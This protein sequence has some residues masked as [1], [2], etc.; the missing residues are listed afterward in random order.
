MARAAGAHARDPV[1][2]D[3][4]SLQAVG[5]ENGRGL[6]PNLVSLTTLGG[7]YTQDFNALASTGTTGSSLPTDWTF[8]ETGGAAPTTYGV[9]TGSS[10][11]GDTWSYGVAGVNPVTD[12]AFGSLGSGTITQVLIGTSFTNNTG[13]QINSLAISYFG[14]QWRMGSNVTQQKLDFQISFDATSLTTGTWTDVNA[15][16]FLSIV[17]SAAAA[18]A[19]DGNAAA[20]RIS[21][22]STITSLTIANGA[23]FWIRW[24]DVND[25]GNDHGLAIDDFSLTPTGAAGSPGTLSIDDVSHVEGNSGATAYTFTVSRTGGS[26]GAVSADYEVFSPGTS[27]FVNA[28]DFVPGS[29]FLGTVNFAD[30]QLSQT[31]TLNIQGDFTIE[32][33]ETFTVLLTNPTGGATITDGSGLGTVTN[34]DSAGSISVN[35][36]S[37]VEGNAGTTAGFFTLTRSGGVSGAVSVDYVIT[38]PGGVGGADGSDVSGTLTGTVN[39]AQGQTSAQIDF[40]INGDVTN[41][42]NETF[43]VAL[44]NPTGGVT[45]GDGAGTATIT[46]DDNPPVISIGDASIVEGNAGVSYISFTIS[47]DKISVDPVTVNYATSDNSATA[48]S[49]Y[50]AVSGQVSFDPGQT[51]KTISVPIIGDTVPEANESF[52]VTLSTPTG[53]TIGDGSATGTITN[54]DGQ[55]YFALGGGNFSQNWT[56]TGLITA[57]DNWS[58]VPFIVGKLGQDIT[59]GTGTNPGTLTGDSTLPNDIDVIANQTSTAITNGGVAEFEIANPTVALQGSGTADAP[60]LILFMDSTGRQDVTVSYRL[61]DIDGTADNA[62]M[63][64]ALQYRIGDSGPWINVPAAFVA[65]A[66]TGPSLA[67]LETV[68]TATLPADANNQAALQIRIMTT[69]AVGND[70]WVGIDDIVVSSNVSAPSLSIADTAVFE[71]NAGTTPISFTVT[72]AG[73]STGA[74]TADW[75][76]TFGSGP[77]DAKAN[78]FVA[79]QLFTGNVSFA[80]GET[81]KVITLNVQG[82]VAAEGDDSFTV[83]LSNPVGGS[84]ADASAIGTIVNDD[85]PP[86][87]ISINDVTVT[88]GD[89]G[90]S[91]MTFTVT[92]TGGSQAFDVDFHTVDDTAFAGEDYVANSGTISFLAGETSKQ[93]SI[94]INGDTDAE[95]AERFQ[96]VL[97]DA[98]N[99]ALILDPVGVGTIAADDP[100]FIH[101]IQGTSYF[102]PILAS[103]GVHN[104]NVASAASVTVRAVVTAVDNVGTRQG[105]YLCE[106]IT[107]WDGN[108]Y[109][110]EGIFVMTRND[111]GV[112]TVVSGVSVGDLV[113]V[114][115]Q[116]MEYQAFSSMPRTVLVNSTGLSILST[117]NPLP[118]VTLTNMPNAVMTGVTPDYFD[119]SDGVG[120]SFDASV[121]A[122]SYYETV[123][124]MLVTIPNM[125]VADGFVTTSGGDPVLQAYSL[126][127]ANPDQINSRGGYTIAGDPP[128]G[129]PDT[130]ETGD[131]THN[132]GRVL[133]DGDVNPDVIEIDFTDF[134]MAPPPGLTQS[135]SMGDHI[136]D[137]TGIIDFDFT[138]RKLFVTSIDSSGATNNVPVRESTALGNDDRALTVAT[139]NVENLDPGD[140]AARF[141]A[142]AD[143]IAN[144]LNAPDILSIEEMQDNNGATASGG[145]DASTTWQMLVDA[146]NLAT[147]AHYQWV[148]QEPVP[149]GEGGEPGGNI[150]VG[151]LYN[152]DRVQL[153]DL[154]PDATLAERRQ[155]TDRLGDGVRDAG[156]LIAYSD[157]MLGGEINPAD[158]TGTRKS[159]LGEFTF[160]GN[161]VYVTANHFPAKG[162]SGNFWQIDQTLETGNPDNSGWDQRNRVGQDLY[163][164]LNLI[165]GGSPNAGIVSGGD[166]NDFYFYRP[167]TTV[168]G[169]TLADGTARIGGA[170]FENLTLSLPEAE[171]YTYTFDGRSQAI[172]HIVV[173]NLLGGVATYDVVHINTGYN[174]LGTGIDAVTRLS[175]HDPG[176]SSYDFRSFAETL[177]GSAAVDTIDGFGGNDTINGAAGNDVLTGNVGDDTLNGGADTDTAVY[178]GPLEDYSFVFEYDLSGH[179]IGFLSVTD[180]NSSNGDEGH[181]TLSSIEVLSFAG[182]AHVAVGDKVTL[183]DATLHFLGTFATIQGAI[184]AASDGYTIIVADGTFNED[185][186]I[187]VDVTIR[188]ANDGTATDDVRDP[189]SV[190][191]GGVTI[192]ANGVTIDGF[193][194]TGAITGP[195]AA[196]ASGIYVQGDDFTLVNTIM[197]G[198]ASAAGILTEQVTG[199]DVGFNQFSGY[200]TGVYVSGGGSAGEIHDNLFQGDG[201]PATGLGNGV[202]SETSGVLI[203]GNVFDGIYGGSLNLFPNGPDT[204]DLNEYVLGNTITNSGAER[205]VQ[206]LP[207]NGTHNVLGTDYNEAFDGETAAANGVTGAFSFNGRGGDDHMWGGQASDSFIGGTGEDEF[208]GEGG[209][210]NLAGGADFDT[211]FYAGNILDYTIV[212]EYNLG[213][214]IIGFL[215]VT[216]NNAGDGDEGHDTLSSIEKL[217]F[218]NAVID[219][220]DPIRLY[221]G[222]DNLVGT[223]TSIQD[224]IDAS[225]DGYRITAE[226]GTYSEDLTVDKDVTIEGANQGLAGTDGGRGAE[227]EIDGS[228]NV[229]AA[230]V[231][232][233]G[234][235]ITGTSNFGFDAGIYLQTDDFTLVNSV[236]NGPDLGGNSFGMLTQL[237][238]NLEVAN[239]LIQG[240]AVGIYISS[241]DSTGSVHDNL[242]QGDGGPITGMGNG[243]NSETSGVTIHDNIFDGIY[244][245][246]INVFPFGPDPVD[247]NTYIFDNLFT[248]NAGEQVIQV[249]PTIDSLN[250]I[251]TD[252]NESF[253]GD[254]SGV[255]G[256]AFSFQGNGGDDKAY[257]GALG[258]TF[259]GGAGSDKLYGLGG[260]DTLTG[261]LDNDFIDGGSG[262]DTANLGTSFG[263]TSTVIGWAMVNSEGNDFLTSVE[264]AQTGTQRNLLVG[265]TALA[266]IQAASN[267][268]VDGDFIQVANGTW[269]GTVT[270]DDANLV[271][272]AQPNAILNTTFTTVT[273]NGITVFGG[274]NADHITTSIGND[275]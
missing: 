119:S 213:G 80:S 198:S 225:S 33:D 94:T 151:F 153:G 256:Q 32:P 162:G 12:R 139:F 27:G 57:N 150:R 173:N 53:A 24:V 131:D 52:L 200:G 235:A 209:N 224:A 128:I 146:V 172:D 121:Y 244:A 251:G 71:G 13:A 149:G 230:G 211:A 202:N 188:G 90:T 145:A 228:V 59:T 267:L 103:E 116:V 252:E 97:T 113:Q 203:Q 35:D 262:I 5:S 187:D 253:N 217:V 51:S 37:F 28:L 168:T 167:L 83:T 102:S 123:E 23:T 96:V 29:V 7:A 231:T 109:T 180:N 65:D 95:F 15:L 271:V 272:I 193:E 232:L 189:E 118:A 243:V 3:I 107:D 61:R 50:V 55:A 111:A 89:A 126:D 159:L 42:P 75:T 81:S 264:I 157:D 215:E 190:I 178:A 120:D 46:N 69:N 1:T 76:V 127:S 38:L 101:M 195:G 73:D 91:L 92:R 155:Y 142:I 130:P 87:L 16:D 112:G 186:V 260:D 110:S 86:S 47:L 196:F 212:Y 152:T 182:G 237:T 223:F 220:N 11:T 79:G 206:I 138:D 171:R 105:Y 175:D 242:F 84:I 44:S 25:A 67:T 273:S 258:D 218:A 191:T 270:Y 125:V 129:P 135:A 36:P 208:T 236:L 82:D 147:G 54:N 117:G 156:D 204:V 100:I 269:G 60:H 257:G 184:D 194:I 275:V 85:G 40:T 140:G 70:E 177:Q 56:N 8:S 19:L 77:F 74:V 241:G 143:A 174:P 160:N 136:G 226:A 164:L 78:D 58:G 183:F 45:I 148:D 169:Y 133:H 266:S 181:D 2:L 222:A 114:S 265:S 274:N 245:G 259:T 98:T 207:T 176:L 43:T 122:L 6:S 106:E 246:V 124:G 179:P 263:I 197:D 141:T 17:N 250:V 62:V 170:R 261:G 63:P 39:F 205:P 234:V 104:F 238:L 219:P 31:I 88:E 268:A 22:S 72:R 229:T 4:A 166:Y 18:S 21:I 216:D 163:S 165:Q 68:V 14:E 99:D 221:D 115:A 132:G 134:A 20:N 210:D 41:E 239:N 49:D 34:D 108:S 233:D 26:T 66:T 30:G 248:D 199:L 185:L 240:Y 137:V 48:G 158:W 227:T 93:V 9:G 255:L 247:L 214:D 144:N 249:Y 254:T 201:G 64:V 192:A 161:T 154:A 10:N